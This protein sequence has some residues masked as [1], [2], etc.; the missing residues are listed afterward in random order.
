MAINGP[1]GD[2]TDRRRGAKAAC[3]SQVFIDGLRVYYPATDKSL[4]DINSLTPEMLRGAEFYA[5][6]ST[7]PAEYSGLGA[8]CGTLLLW[9]K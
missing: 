6:P 3:Y 4:F 9:T 8:N 2:G 7:T 5:G 1:S